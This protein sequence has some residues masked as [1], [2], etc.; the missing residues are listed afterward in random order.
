MSGIANRYKETILD[1]VVQCRKCLW[2]AF[3][4]YVIGGYLDASVT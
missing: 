3:S 1:A 4:L 2:V